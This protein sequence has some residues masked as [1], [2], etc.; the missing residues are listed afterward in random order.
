VLQRKDFSKFLIYLFILLVFHSIG[1]G[2]IKYSRNFPHLDRPFY[3]QL[4]IN[5]TNPAK[6]EKIKVVSFNIK[7]SEKINK[8][9]EQLEED[10]LKNADIILLQ[11]MDNLDVGKIANTLKYNYVYYP[12]SM[13]HDKEFGNAILTKWPIKNPQKIILPHL[14][15]PKKRQ[16]IVVAATVIINNIE[17]G[18]YSVHL[19]TTLTKSQRAEQ[20]DTVIRAISS[21]GIKRCVIGG[22]FNTYSDDHIKAIVALLEEAGFSHASKHIDWTFKYMMLFIPVKKSALDHIFTRGMKTPLNYGRVRNNKKASD[23]LPIWVEL[24]LY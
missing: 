6:K 13:K 14:D 24:E 10:D 1:C 2:I 8:A 18:I 22:D 3:Q 23:H 12:A 20:V 17:M 16:R 5:T 15:F 11:E 7:F 4:D 9:I 21:K 19:G